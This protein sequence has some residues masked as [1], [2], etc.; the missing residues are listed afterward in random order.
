MDEQKRLD[1]ESAL[2]AA[3]ERREE[4]STLAKKIARLVAESR[5]TYADLP[6]LWQEVE[7]GL[8]FRVD[9]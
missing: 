5:T 9:G 2:K 7:R 6:D 3:R 1:R 4:Q 8:R